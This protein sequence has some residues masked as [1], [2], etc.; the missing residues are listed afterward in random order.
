MVPGQRHHLY[1]HLKLVLFVAAQFAAEPLFNG[2]V[3]LSSLGPVAQAQIVLGQR[4]A[5]YLLAQHIPG[6]RN[7]LYQR[8]QQLN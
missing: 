6:R 1:C 8:L 4:P 7:R 3:L 5:Q 2:I